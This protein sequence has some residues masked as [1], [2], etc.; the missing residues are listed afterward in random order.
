LQEVPRPVPLASAQGMA[1]Q[2]RTPHRSSP[3][4]HEGGDRPMTVSIPLVLIAG[5]LVYLAWRYMGLRIWQAIVCL[6]FGFLLAATTAGPEIHSLITGF[7]QWL[8]K[9]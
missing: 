4:D 6:L 7:I 9:S 2:S 8:T 5:A 1:D 3:D